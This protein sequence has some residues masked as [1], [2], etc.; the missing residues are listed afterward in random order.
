MMLQGYLDSRSVLAALLTLIPQLVVSGCCL[1]ILLAS[2]AVGASIVAIITTTTA[3]LCLF[4]CLL[5]LCTFE[6]FEH[7]LQHTGVLVA[8]I[9]IRFSR[10]RQRIAPEHFGESLF[11]LGIGC[12]PPGLIDRIVTSE[13]GPAF[14]GPLSR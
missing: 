2:T 5:C 10:Q 3:G 1:P 8:M 4:V 12:P 13:V 14:H 6:I 7:T 11:S 9:G